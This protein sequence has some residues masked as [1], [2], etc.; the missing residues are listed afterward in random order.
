M[1]ITSRQNPRIKQLVKLRER[2]YRDR[3]GRMLIEGYRELCR[4]LDGKH[5]PDCVYYCVSMFQGGNE[6]ALLERCR[7]AGAA[8][9]E[10]SVSVFEK[11]SYRDRPE[12][13][14]ATAEAAGL[15]LADV[16]DPADALVLVAEAIEKPGNLGT[17]LRTADAAGVSAVIVCDPRTDINNPNVVRASLGTLFT[18]PVAVGDGQTVHAWL[19]ERG[20]RMLAATPH[21]VN[22]YD[23]VC[24]TG[25]T[26]LLLGAEQY[27]LSA[28]WLRH[29]D[30]KIRIPMAGYADSLNVAAAATILLFE[31]VRQRREAR[32]GGKRGG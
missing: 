5:F 15:R 12:G 24:M 21:T 16:P 23:R 9:I 1:R 8:L 22:D 30:Q 19:H 32:S 3:S 20:Y 10:C 27:G 31:A 28:F 26:A 7:A 4:A 13:L 17:M 18:M 29:A 14:L 2:S 11:I 25:K 6:N